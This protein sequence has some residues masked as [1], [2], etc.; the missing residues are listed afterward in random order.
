MRNPSGDETG[1]QHHRRKSDRDKEKQASRF[2]MGQMKLFL[3]LHQQRR[4]D[5]TRKKC[6][7][8]NPIEKQNGTQYPIDT[9]QDALKPSRD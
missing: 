1:Y 5:N 8:E 3:N 7:K 6:E 9:F 4:K 2:H